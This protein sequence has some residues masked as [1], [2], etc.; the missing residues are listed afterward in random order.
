MTGSDLNSFHVP[1]AEHVVIQKNAP[2]T[3]STEPAEVRIMGVHRTFLWTIILFRKF[4]V[5]Q[6]PW[7]FPSHIL[8]LTHS[9]RTCVRYMDGRF[10]VLFDVFAAIFSHGDY[11]IWRSIIHL[12]SPRKQH[13]YENE[14]YESKHRYTHTNKHTCT[15]IVPFSSFVETI[16]IIMP[17][18]NILQNIQITTHNLHTLLVKTIEMDIIKVCR[19][20]VRCTEFSE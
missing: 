14:I 10:I 12:Y 18:E 6:C 11:L 8:T 16:I 20:S 17:K 4:P 1:K 7:T 3:S 9:A 19:K 13:I 15:N 5:G 2:D